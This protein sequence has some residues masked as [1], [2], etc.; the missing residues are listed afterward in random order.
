MN[1]QPPLLLL[2]VHDEDGYREWLEVNL[3][4]GTVSFDV[5]YQMQW[6]TTHSWWMDQG[7]SIRVEHIDRVIEALQEAKRRAGGAS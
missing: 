2:P 6:Q 1:D 4:N 3:S 7:I 5:R